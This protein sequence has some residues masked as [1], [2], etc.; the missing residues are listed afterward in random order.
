MPKKPDKA[1][2]YEQLGKMVTEIYETGYL[3]RGRM[4]KTSFL[5]GV[6]TGFGGVVGATLVVA[7]VLWL[8]DTFDIVPFA[9]DIKELIENSR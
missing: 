2:Q 5:K 7:V 6:M 3:D 9:N 8:L 4:L 1:K